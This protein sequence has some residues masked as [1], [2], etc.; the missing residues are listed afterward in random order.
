MQYAETLIMT[1]QGH[2]ASWVNFMLLI[3]ALIGGSVSV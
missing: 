3:L 1:E 2:S